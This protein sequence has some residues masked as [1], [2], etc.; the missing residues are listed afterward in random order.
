MNTK[1]KRIYLFLE[2][3]L[4]FF[5]IPLVLTVKNWLSDA[6]PIFLLPPLFLLFLLYFRLQKNFSLK[7]FFRFK[8]P[9]K[10]LLKNG[11][12]LLLATLLLVLYVLF[13]ERENLLNLPRNNIRIWFLMIVGY[14]LISAFIQEVIYRTF[15]FRRY[16][17]LFQHKAVTI[18]TG[19]LAFS[20][21]HIVYYSLF[22]I[23][24]TFIL[25]IYLGYIYEK[26]KSV[27]FTTLL[28]GY[29]GNVVFTVGLGHH[30]W[31]NM[32]QYL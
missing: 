5:G 16:S 27:L 20:F 3:L 25:G 26:T 21:V 23:I 14:P 11:L 22:S 18:I 4:L 9:L 19:A 13:F 15:L 6:H 1:I 31:Q 32:Q 10:M 2:F 29:L 12:I 30:F 28:H 7:S 24:T 17:G 8:I